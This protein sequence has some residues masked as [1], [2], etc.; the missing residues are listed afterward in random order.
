MNTLLHTIAPIQ[1]H[2]IIPIALHWFQTAW[3]LF[4][5][6]FGAL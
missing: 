1:H 5:Q 6:P 3:W 4:L 2:V